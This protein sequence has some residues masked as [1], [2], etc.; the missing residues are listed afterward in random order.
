MASPVKLTLFGIVA[1]FKVL[2]INICEAEM[3]ILDTEVFPKHAIAD[4]NSEIKFHYFVKSGK[5]LSLKG[6][7]HR[8]THTNTQHEYIDGKLAGQHPKTKCIIKRH[9]QQK[10]LST[11]KH[12]YLG[13][14]NCVELY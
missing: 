7:V 11:T 9:I 12:V 13:S 14:S 2:F 8:S 10:T 5:A 6:N 4:M 3:K 1:S